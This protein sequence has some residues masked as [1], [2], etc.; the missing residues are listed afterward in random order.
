MQKKAKNNQPKWKRILKKT[1]LTLIIVLL[2]FLIG[3][4]AYNTLTAKYRRTFTGYNVE[5]GSIVET[6][7][8][9]GKI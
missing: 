6:N 3:W 1:L 5:T 4:Y 9:S 2:L 7:E 8:Y